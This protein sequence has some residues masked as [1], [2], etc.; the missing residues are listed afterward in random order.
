MKPHFHILFSILFSAIL[1]YLNKGPWFI[2]PFFLA[3]VLIDV[4]HYLFYIFK[5]KNFNLVKAYR[6]Y[7][8]PK[9]ELFIFHTIEFFILFLLLTFLFTV[10]PFSFSFL[11]WTIFFGILFHQVLDIIHDSFEKKKE[12]K[13]K[14]SLIMYLLGK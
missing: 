4:D 10:F 13:S 2:L 6:Y 1:F 9:R 3:S 12:Y 11:L 5:K 7:Q 8:K 14:Y